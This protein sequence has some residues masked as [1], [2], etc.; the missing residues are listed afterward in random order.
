MQLVFRKGFINIKQVTFDNIL[1]ALLSFNR[2]KQII[3]K[4]FVYFSSPGD[5]LVIH[6][7]WKQKNQTVTGGVLI[8][9]ILVSHIFE[10]NCYLE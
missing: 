2:E 9:D 4:S 6:S 1:I 8:A 7:S 10:R 3:E 5:S